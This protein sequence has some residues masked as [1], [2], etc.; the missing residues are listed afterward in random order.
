[1]KKSRF[2]PIINFRQTL[3]RKENNAGR[4]PSSLYSRPAIKTKT[5]I[6]ILFISY[7]L[8]SLEKIIHSFGELFSDY[9]CPACR[10]AGNLKKLCKYKKYYYQE[11][12]EIL[13]L[14][15]MVCGTTHAIIPSFS[16]PGT[17]IGTKEAEEYIHLREK[18]LGRKTAGKILL[19]KRG[20]SL[21]CLYNLEKS[22]YTATA[23]AKVI[24][25]IAALRPVSGLSWLRSIVEEAE[26]GAI[27]NFNHYCLSEG[28]N[29][30]YLSRVNIIHFKKSKGGKGNSLNLE[31]LPFKK[32]IVNSC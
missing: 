16:L 23:R 5:N 8:Y 30:I 31:S 18:G 32:I 12:I 25:N 15:C 27:N 20:L 14:I 13:R 21:G 17:S 28:V 1:M 3:D 26:E 7:E 6:I 29:A 4:F 9:S 22:F 19:L 24:F 11:R 2:Y 10:L